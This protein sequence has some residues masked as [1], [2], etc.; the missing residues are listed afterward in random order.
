MYI[1]GLSA[2]NHD[3]A[4]ALI[5]DG[6][7]VCAIEEE[8]FTRIKHDN[9]FPIHAIEWC[10]KEAEITVNDIEIISYYEKPLLKF[11]RTVDLFIQTWPKSIG[12]F[13]H[14]LPGLL[15]EKLS[16]ENTIRKKL[17]YAGRV[18][19]IPHHLSHA[20]AAYYSSPFNSAA[21]LT[22]DGVGEYQTTALWK[23]SKSGIKLL[24]DIHFPHSLGLFY[25]ACTAYLG[26]K[27]NEDEYKLMGLAAYGKPLYLSKFKKVIDRKK[28]GSFH[29]NM[30]YF[31]FRE[32]TQ[33]WSRAFEK[34]LGRPRLPEEKISA[35][36]ADIAKSVQTLTEQAY[37]GILDHLQNCTHENNICIG[38]GGAL[39]ALANGL[40]HSQTAFQKSHIFGP[41]GDS[42][43]ALGSALFTH[44]HLI[45]VGVIR[46]MQIQSQITSLSLGSHYSNDAIK[47]V[48][49]KYNLSYKKLSQTELVRS[50]AQAL[51]EGKI[52]GWFQGRCEFG[53]RA[54]GNRSILCR[55]SPRNMKTRVNFIKIREQFR[56]FAGSI[57][58]SH[59]QDYFEVPEKHFCAPFM[60]YCFKVKKDKRKELAALVHTDGT[61]RIQ[62]V[63]MLNS[64]DFNLYYKL[65]SEFY[66]LSGIPCILNTSFN[67]KGEPIVESP[68]QAIQ[69]FL[70]TNMDILYL[71]NNKVEK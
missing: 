60:N 13:I 71:G 30:N 50:A 36:H 35:R 55:P 31:S 18:V 27:V 49:K 68:E 4:A 32:S 39:N 33:M 11:E 22:I 8:R 29:L 5:K 38:G 58:Q 26:F 65:I 10:L 69:V 54:L 57:A 34:L 70:K 37:I 7:V 16:I 9:G 62:T 12:L 15:G 40:I 42:G 66:L 41:S 46:P 14:G 21:I 51:Y 63:S 2:Y 17:H 23:A 52:I 6:R 3:S 47:S 53:P 20:A 48:L 44:H 25:S 24:K 19:F 59:V 64:S 56:P 45:A 61:C 1:L 28:D 67:L 43:A